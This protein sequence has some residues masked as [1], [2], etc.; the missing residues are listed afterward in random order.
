MQTWRVFTEPVTFMQAK[1][2]GAVSKSTTNSRH[3]AY[4]TCM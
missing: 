2:S 1:S 4:T 3:L